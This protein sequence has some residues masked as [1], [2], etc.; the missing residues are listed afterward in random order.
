MKTNAAD[1]IWPDVFGSEEVEHGSCRGK[2]YVK[3]PARFR[4]PA[5]CPEVCSRYA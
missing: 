1:V 5:Q 4:N 3:L 2:K